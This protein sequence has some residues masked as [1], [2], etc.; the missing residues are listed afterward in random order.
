METDQATLQRMEALLLA[1]EVRMERAQ[2]KRDIRAGKLDARTILRDPPVHWHSAKILDLLL[3]MPKIGRVK[4]N[5]WLKMEAISP[6][7]R[8]EQFTPSQRERLARHIDTDTL[9]RDR[10]RRQMEV[11]S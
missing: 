1:N 9:R 6:L 11:V 7:R 2:D 5:R 10:L 3:E 8:L 4:A